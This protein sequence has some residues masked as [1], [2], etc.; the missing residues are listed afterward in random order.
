MREVCPVVATYAKYIQNYLEDEVFFADSYLERLN[1][2]AELIVGQGMI[3]RARQHQRAFLCIELSLHCIAKE[4]QV[5]EEQSSQY[6]RWERSS[7]GLSQLISSMRGNNED[8]TGASMEYKF[9]RGNVHVTA[10]HDDTVVVQ[11]VGDSTDQM[12]Q[13]NRHM[14]MEVYRLAGESAVIL[15]RSLRNTEVP[16]TRVGMRLG[17]AAEVARVDT[18]RL[19]YMLEA[20]LD[21]TENNAPRAWELLQ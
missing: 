18:T 5:R 10:K 16:L 17:Q 14:L 12:Y 4:I 8:L 19:F 13:E 11:R 20:L 6:L 9:D 1:H 3:S 15:R 2:Y 7:M 21:Q